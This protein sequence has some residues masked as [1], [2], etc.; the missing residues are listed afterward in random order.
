MSNRSRSSCVMRGLSMV[1]VIAVTLLIVANEKRMEDLQTLGYLGAFLAMLLSNAT[2]VL[3]APGLIFV[4]A[5]G[6][7]LNPLLVGLAAAVGATM[8]E[9][10]GYMTGY[11]GLAILDQNQIAQR[12]N[13]WMTE[14]GL[15][16]VFVLSIIPNPLFDIAGILAG[17]SRMPIWQFFGSAFFGKTIQSTLIALAGSMSINWAQDLLSHS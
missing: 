11:S 2:L 6:S 8:G 17:V 4:F 13:G 15:L 10:T 12:I 5:L 7:S 16:T 9:I 1:L 3:P 14:H